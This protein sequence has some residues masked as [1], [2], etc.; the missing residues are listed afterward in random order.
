M[1]VRVILEILIFTGLAAAF[2]YL[3]IQLWKG[4]RRHNAEK[5]ENAQEVLE[6]VQVEKQEKEILAEAK[7]LH[8]EMNLRQPPEEIPVPPKRPRSPKAVQ[9]SK[10][11]KKKS[12]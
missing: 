4:T 10:V 12:Q 5:L 7:R 11:S 6:N 9:K 1:I 3:I 2:V 8:D